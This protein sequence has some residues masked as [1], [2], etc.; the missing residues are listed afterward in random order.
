M[1]DPAALPANPT[2]DDLENHIAEDCTAVCVGDPQVLADLDD[3]TDEQLAEYI[4]V[5]HDWHDRTRTAP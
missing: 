5:M 2:R 4:A 1:T 3:A